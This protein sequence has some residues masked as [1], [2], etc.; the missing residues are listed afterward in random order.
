MY[1]ESSVWSSYAHACTPRVICIC[2]HTHACTYAHVHTVHVQELSMHGRKLGV[3]AERIRQAGAGGNHKQNR[4]R[5]HESPEWGPGLGFL[6]RL[7]SVVCI[8]FFIIS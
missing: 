3:Q 8:V 2:A 7:R 4:A 1:T 6:A 5:L